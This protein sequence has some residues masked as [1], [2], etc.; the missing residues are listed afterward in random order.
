LAG[1]H[2]DIGHLFVQT[3]RP[4][5]AIAAFEKARAIFQ[6][7]ADANPRVTAYR[8]GIAINYSGVGGVLSRMGQPTE[9]LAAWEN[10]RAQMQELSDANP[11][12]TQFQRELAVMHN[13]VAMKLAETGKHA[14]ALL[15]AEKGRAIR[16]ALA[17]A[18]PKV[19]TFQ[20]DVAISLMVIGDLRE[21][22]DNP[23]EAAEAYRKALA[24][25]ERIPTL[26]VYDQFNVCNIHAKLAELAV[27]PG[28]GLSPAE[29]PAEAD[30]AVS[31]LRK[32]VDGGLRPSLQAWDAPNLKSLRAHPGFRLLR[33][34]LDIPNDP[35]A[36]G[37]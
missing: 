1:S 19:M 17:D 18:N 29:G 11:N 27:T 14:E 7:L 24:I 20:R 4:K 3:G 34:D 22:E 30:R 15:A 26:P 23:A 36:R 28:S 31:W 6:S 16:Q 12:I 33:M 8:R 32:A 2:N 37:L 9:S 21:N 10:A 13:N 5:E 25:L 35:F